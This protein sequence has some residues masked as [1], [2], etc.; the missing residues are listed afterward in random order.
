MRIAYISGAELP[1]RA[2][3]SVQI[4]K[5]C[6]AFIKNGHNVT[7][8]GKS[9]I[10]VSSKIDDFYEIHKDLD[11]I[12]T[13]FYKVK[14]VGSLIFSYILSKK[15]K[16][17]DEYDILYGRHS[18]S[19]YFLR[20]FGRPIIYEAHA[21]PKRKL[22]KYLEGKIFSS[23]NF[24]KLVVISNALKEDYIKEFPQIEEKDIIVAH[25]GA[26]L[27]ELKVYENT[28]KIGIDNN[29][30]YVGS[31][32]PGKGMEII[33]NIARRMPN[34]NFHIVG[35]K[36]DDI[37]LWKE[38]TKEYKNIIYHGFVPNKKLHEYYKL[39]NI[40]I[41]PY[42]EQVQSLGGQNIE[43]W[44]SPLKIFEYMS[45]KKAIIA[46]DLPIIREVLINDHNSL[47]CNVTKIED[48]ENAIIK[49]TTNKQIAQKISE[50]G[51]E[52]LQRLYT[53]NKRAEL[54]LD[55]N[56]KQYNKY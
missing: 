29:I 5:M 16:K 32:Y 49:L 10:I 22:H 31:L 41:A 28:N 53:W 9:N 13:R 20:K 36:E 6:N 8:Y 1:S 56:I 33:Y 24:K 45:F 46:S 43:K 26:E 19:L 18:Y 38:K 54:V 42:K 15:V 7:L 51:F 39:F 21:M 48:W 55:S 44:M 25:D 35:G 4:I 27:Q 3:N 37:A 30:G 17:S 2:A 47:L 50:N 40:A 12:T 23:N 52:D 34:Y 14:L 11:I